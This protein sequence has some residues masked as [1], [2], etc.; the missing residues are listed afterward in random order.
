MA[1]GEAPL[2]EDQ[3]G[4]KRAEAA[5]G[6]HETEVTGRAAEL[7]AN[8]VRD[9]HLDGAPVR[10]QE[11]G[12]GQKRRPEPGVCPDE[13][14]SLAQ[15]AQHGRSAF[16]HLPLDRPA[17]PDQEDGRRRDEK[18]HGVEK[19]CLAGTEAGHDPTAQRGADEQEAERPDELVERVGLEQEGARDDLGDDRR[20]RGAEERLAEA[21]HRR[22]RDQMPELERTG[23]GEHRDRCGSPGPDDVGRDHD[24]AAFDPIRDHTS[25]QDE[26]PERKRPGEPDQRQRSGRV[27]ELV[28]LPRNR[29]DID[30]VPDQ[31]DRARRPRAA[32]SP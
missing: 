24:A 26:Q 4:Q 17:A 5:E 16:A 29:H 7:V 15:V 2:A 28:H 32:R 25:D 1:A 21:E 22:E 20:E 6:E 18:S 12:R 10:E 11:H 14:D 3:G 27:R 23:Q 31:R 8:A 19:E 9:E 13:R 30:P